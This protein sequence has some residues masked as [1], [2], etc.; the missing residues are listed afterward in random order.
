MR[1]AEVFSSAGMLLD[2]ERHALELDERSQAPEVEET[3]TALANVHDQ[4]EQS[5]P[6]GASRDSLRRPGC[7]PCPGAPVVGAPGRV[8]VDWLSGERDR[9]SP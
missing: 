3:R 6:A 2:A 5:S 8:V 4:M 7:C 1:L 9:A